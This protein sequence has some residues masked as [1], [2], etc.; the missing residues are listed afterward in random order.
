MKK[1]IS[2]LILGI[3]LTSCAD[4][5]VKEKDAQVVLKVNYTNNDEQWYVKDHKYM[6]RTQDF[7]FATDSLYRVGDTLKIG[8]KEFKKDE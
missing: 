2:T 6:V 5:L 1:I 4:K 8:K 3:T 7:D